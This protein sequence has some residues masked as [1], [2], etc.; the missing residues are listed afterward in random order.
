MTS[1]YRV[2]LS[3][4]DVVVRK[5]MELQ[6][7]FETAFLASGWPKEAAMFSNVDTLSHHFYFSPGAVRIA[8][9]VIVHYEGAECAPPAMSDLVLLVGTPEWK[10]AIFP[11]EV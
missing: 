5:H 2:T 11:D 4:K 9:D 10:S 3:D 7:A 8:N 6:L 1:W